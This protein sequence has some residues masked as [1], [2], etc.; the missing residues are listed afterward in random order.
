MNKYLTPIFIGILI[1][2]AACH[3]NTMAS[4]NSEENRNYTKDTC[5]YILNVPANIDMPSTPPFDTIIHRN[6]SCRVHILELPSW[7]TETS[8]TITSEAGDKRS[9]HFFTDEN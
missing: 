6:K 9:A 7:G 8:Y 3:D 5:R 1:I 4:F 2:A